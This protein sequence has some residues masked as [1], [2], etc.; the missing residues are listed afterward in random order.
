MTNDQTYKAKQS[1]VQQGYVSVKSVNN[2]NYINYIKVEQ[3]APKEPTTLD[4][5]AATATFP[6]NL[7]TEGQTATFSKPDYWLTSKVTLGS[8]LFIKGMDAKQQGQTVVQ[9]N[10]KETAAG[11]T[12]AIRFLIQPKFGFTFTPTKV[13]LKAA[14]YG[15]D[16][17]TIDISWLNADNTTVSLKT[18]QAVSRDAA[19]KFEFDVTGATPGEGIC[20]I[21]VNLYGLQEGKNFGLSDI[22]IEGTLSGTEKDLPILASF[23]ANGTEYTVDEV[24]G[25]LYEAD[26][27]LSK[28]ESMIS[29]S[30]PLTEI[31]ATSG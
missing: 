24:F 13:S 14:K 12:N 31:T 2:N 26:L 8:N 5:E 30:N 28:S 21:V 15:T 16:N 27:E 6:F 19:T 7:G 11:E 10:G 29:E 22:I 17:G 25:D 20:G 18:G 23:K 9:T 1:D 4:N 3:K